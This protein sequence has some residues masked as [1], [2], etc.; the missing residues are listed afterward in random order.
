MA[1]TG[2]QVP[3]S[4]YQAPDYSGA[5]KAAG[6]LG[7]MPSQMVTGFA[8]QV[9]DYLKQQKEQVKSVTTASRIAGM[10]ESKAP[11][12]IPGIGELKATLEDQ[13]IPLSQRIAAAESLFDL[14][15]V[16]Y[17]VKDYNNKNRLLEM[18]MQRSSEAQSAA[19]DT[20][21]RGR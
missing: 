13:E 6:A 20:S 10:L 21:R 14:M 19:Q 5:V 18:Q 7:A 9:Q 1:L 2:G 11:D 3:V 12:L 8:G 15:K 17:E 16:G 4:G